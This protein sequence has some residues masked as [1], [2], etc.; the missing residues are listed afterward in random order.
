MIAKQWSNGKAITKDL[1]KN[2]REFM[3]HW[4]KLFIAEKAALE[5]FDRQLEDA[6]RKHEA[7]ASM[8]RFLGIDP[9]EYTVKWKAGRLKQSVTYL[10]YDFEKRRWSKPSD[11]GFATASFANG[12][13]SSAQ[14]FIK[15]VRQ[16]GKR[17]GI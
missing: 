16:E 10:D 11:L 17:L 13:L 2:K 6:I 1:W 12:H 9:H 4:K 7:D 5:S 3:S 8:T 15:V 14:G